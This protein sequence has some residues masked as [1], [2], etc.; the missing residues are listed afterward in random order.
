MRGMTTASGNST[1]NRSKR[2]PSRRPHR[3]QD[4]ARTQLA[5]LVSSAVA[6]ETERLQQRD[7]VSPDEFFIM[8]VSAYD[9]TQPDPAHDLVDDP[10]HD[11]YDDGDYGC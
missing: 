8:A 4:E 11:A 1:G 10:A 6:A 5:F 3:N 9:L 2:R 7:N